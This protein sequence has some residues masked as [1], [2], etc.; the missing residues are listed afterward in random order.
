MATLKTFALRTGKFALA[1]V[2]VVAV[3]VLVHPVAAIVFV[4][5]YAVTWVAK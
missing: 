2:A 3:S 5:P 1:M 4:V